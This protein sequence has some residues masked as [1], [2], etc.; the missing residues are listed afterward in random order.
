M[1]KYRNSIVIIF[2]C[3]SIVSCAPS[4]HQHDESDYHPA[5]LKELTVVIDKK[6]INDILAEET[7]I[8]DNLR[9]FIE[10]GAEEETISYQS[11][12]GQK[13]SSSVASLLEILEDAAKGDRKGFPV[14]RGLGGGDAEAFLK[15]VRLKIGTD[16]QFNANINVVVKVRGITHHYAYNDKKGSGYIEN[17]VFYDFMIDGKL[18]D[19]MIFYWTIGI[20]PGTYT[21][22]RN[23][24]NGKDPFPTADMEFDESMLKNI[25]DRQLMYKLYAKGTGIVVLGVYRDDVLLDRRNRLYTSTAES[26]IDWMFKNYPPAHYGNLPPIHERCLG[27]CEHPALMNTGT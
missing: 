1:S 13:S 17:E 4:H 10:T 18:V 6:N 25:E 23:S 24:G 15:A 21:V 26:C 3:L 19:Q 7:S 16:G 12:E 14:Q 2:A 8:L 5:K 9:G 27:R 22:H 20:R 11:Y